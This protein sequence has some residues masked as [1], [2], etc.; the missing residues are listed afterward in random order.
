MLV[1]FAQSASVIPNRNEDQ[2]EITKMPEMP[3]TP[4]AVALTLLRIIGETEKWNQGA[5]HWK[6]T[7]DEILD[8]YAECLK[9]A[10]DLR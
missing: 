9:A 5:G 4:E 6:K 10:K 8:T 2:M 1:I 7:K 3:Q